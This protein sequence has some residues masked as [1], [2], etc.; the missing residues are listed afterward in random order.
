MAVC[1]FESEFKRL[2]GGNEGSQLGRTSGGAGMESN[3]EFCG[4][5][6]WWC[7]STLSSLLLLFCSSFFFLFH[8]L[9]SFNYIRFF[10]LRLHPLVS[11][12]FFSLFP[13][14]RF[15]LVCFLLLLSSPFYLFILVPFSS[16]SFHSSFPVS[17]S[18]SPKLIPS[19]FFH[20]KNL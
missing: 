10:L 2:F 1:A 11:S 7:S 13:V 15:R 6:W 19:N 16:F 8:V 20:F 17:S 12:S 3:C 5:W 18:S 4:C 14:F 9:F